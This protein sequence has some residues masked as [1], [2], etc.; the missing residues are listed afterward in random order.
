MQLRNGKVLTASS[1]QR[2]AWEE[3]L[4]NIAQRS[5]DFLDST[6]PHKET[7]NDMQLC[8]SEVSSSPPRGI[9]LTSEETLIN[10]A[11]RTLNLLESTS[12]TKTVTN[13]PT[14][15][16]LPPEIRLMIFDSA[17][18]NQ[19]SFKVCNCPPIPRNA[20]GEIVC[21]QPNPQRFPE[22]REEI[23]RRPINTPPDFRKTL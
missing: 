16:T 9:G 15:Q 8:N 6:T 1:M 23:Q 14:F 2:S 19:P 10:I 17:L 20:R 13:N 3:S 12:S 7:N 4:Q 11:Q 22:Q 18:L 5:L 21:P